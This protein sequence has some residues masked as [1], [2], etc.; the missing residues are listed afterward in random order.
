MSAEVDSIVRILLWIALIAILYLNYRAWQQ[1]YALA[2]RELATAM[3]A[4]SPGVLATAPPRTETVGAAQIVRVRTDVLDIDIDLHGGGLRRA[5]L[6]V[7]PQ[8]KGHPEPV[9]LFNEDR[10]ET[11]FALYSGLTGPDE[12]LRPTHR[13]TFSSA[14]ADFRLADDARELRVPLT[15]TDHHGVRVTKT[16]VFHRGSYRISIEQHV[17]NTSGAAWVTAPYVQLLRDDP[18]VEGSMLKAESR[19]FRGPAIYDG[20]AYRKL[21]IEKQTDARLDQEV[22]GG[23]LAALQHHFVAAIVPLPSEPYRYTLDAQGREYLLS[24][25]GGERTVAPGASADFDTTVFVGPKLQAQLEATGTQLERVADYGLLTP[26]AKPLFWLLSKVH[27]GVGNWGW[28][29]VIVT[30]LLKLVFYPL[31]EA[32][33]RSMAKMKALAPGIKALQEEHK[34]DRDAL[35]RAMMDLYRREKVNPVSGCVPTI[36]QFPV[37]A[38]LYWV[39]LESAEMRQAPFAGWITDLSAHDPF[40]I[41][42]AIMA[43]A[44]FAQSRLQGS[45]NVDPMQRKMLTLMPIAMS[46]MFALLPAG[47][48]LYYV[49]NTL[50]SIA[51]QWN[52]NR[53]LQL[54]R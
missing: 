11:R 29:I 33:G 19:A 27:A 35:G 26:I 8:V 46:A 48:V 4:Q 53:R 40:F 10:P 38:A 3:V 22:T 2:K 17:E 41:L 9:R 47:L 39:L 28:A 5:D 37:F 23:W 45:T 18:K 32:S 49:V 42:P 14:A 24:A 7:Y 44:M 20:R 1:D 43:A 54:A 52:I 50:L 51:Q 6:L 13:A 31:S 16:F 34:E 15:W 25:V 30:A 21:D 12:S 36:L